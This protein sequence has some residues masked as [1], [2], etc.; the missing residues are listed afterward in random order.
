LS[1]DA[2]LRAFLEVPSGKLVMSDC[3]DKQHKVKDN[4]NHFLARCRIED[5][6][7]AEACLI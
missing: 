6:E 5:T 4:I 2:N 7:I 1:A 3:Y